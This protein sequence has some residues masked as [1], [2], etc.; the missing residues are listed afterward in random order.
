MGRL[1]DSQTY[2]QTDSEKQYLYIFFVCFAKIMT[3]NMMGVVTEMAE[4]VGLLLFMYDVINSSVNN[5]A[6]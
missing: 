5:Y 1:T 2:I 6:E 4:R 3:C